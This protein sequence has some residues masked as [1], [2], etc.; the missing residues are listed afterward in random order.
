MLVS[1]GLAR[2]L[3]VEN[4]DFWFILVGYS[5]LFA[6]SPIM[7]CIIIPLHYFCVFPKTSKFA[8]RHF[9]LSCFRINHIILYI[10]GFVSVSSD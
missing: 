5:P 10:T 7:C 8:L 9:F 1:Q 2:D 6:F 4:S 3:G